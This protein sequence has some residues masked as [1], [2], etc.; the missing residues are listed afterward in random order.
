[1]MR[2]IDSRLK[3]I[4]GFTIRG[5]LWSFEGCYVHGCHQ[6]TDS[7]HPALSSTVPTS[8]NGFTDALRCGTGGGDKPQPYGGSAIEMRFR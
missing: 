5:N 6:A 3:E 2:L 8:H 1:M 7:S 4:A